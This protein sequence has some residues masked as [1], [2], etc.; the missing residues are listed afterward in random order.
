[1][2]YGCLLDELWSIPKI[3]YYGRVLEKQN[4]NPRTKKKVKSCTAVNETLV[5]L[6]F[7]FFFK[8]RI[9]VAGET[10]N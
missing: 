3:V 2:Q 10:V 9:S 1:M 8:K 7:D 4:I 5:I 6:N